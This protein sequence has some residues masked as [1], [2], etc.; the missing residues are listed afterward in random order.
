MR[1]AR[2]HGARDVTGD[3][4]DHLVAGARLSEFR[5]QRVAVVVP[6]ALHPGFLADLDPGRLER[7]V[8]SLG[9]GVPKANT[10]HSGRHS[11]N[12]RVYQAACASIAAMAVSFSGI[13]R[14]VPASVFDLPTVS[15]FL[16][17]RS[18][19]FH[20]ISRNSLSRRPVFRSNASAACICGVRNFCACS[21]IRGFSSALYGRPGEAGSLSGV[22][23]FSALTLYGDEKAPI[24][25]DDFMYLPV[26]MK[27]GIANSSSAPVKVIV[28][29]YKIPAD[30]KVQPTAKL[31]LAR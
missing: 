11:P 30:M 3:A 6:A 4:H 16:W 17:I 2:E 10:N 28:M 21:S 5:Y 31:M 14:P 1:V 22:N 13:T 9:R 23:Y 7:R 20:R 8:G 19:C 27:H 24:K 15:A 26:G 25:A 18:I 12:L 29:G